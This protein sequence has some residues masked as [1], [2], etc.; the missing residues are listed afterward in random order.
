[1]GRRALDLPR[2]GT[3]AAPASD[4]GIEG[5]LDAAR[6]DLIDSLLSGKREGCAMHLFHPRGYVEDIGAVSG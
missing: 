1:V 3:A 5:A 4:G 6:A 2:L